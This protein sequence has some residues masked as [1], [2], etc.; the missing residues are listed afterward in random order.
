LLRSPVDFRWAYT[1]PPS[2]RT[3]CESV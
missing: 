3:V 2:R 1:G